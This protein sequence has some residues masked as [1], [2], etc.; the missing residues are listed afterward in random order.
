MGLQ[1]FPGGS[2]VK[3]SACNAGDL[4]SI[5]GLGRSPGEG[6]EDP[7]EKE[8]ATHSSVLG[9]R[10]PGTAEPGGLPSMGSHRVGHDWSDSSSG[11][12]LAPQ[13]KPPGPAKGTSK[14]P[15]PGREPEGTSDHCLCLAPGGNLSRTISQIAA[16][17]CDPGTQALLS[18]E[19]V[20]PVAAAKPETHEGAKHPR[21]LKAV[22]EVKWPP[23]GSRSTCPQ[24][25]KRPAGQTPVTANTSGEQMGLS[26]TSRGPLGQAWPWALELVSPHELFRRELSSLN[27]LRLVDRALLV[28]EASSFGSS[29][30]PSEGLQSR[31]GRGCPVGGPNF[32]PRRADLRGG[33]GKMG[34]VGL[35]CPL[36]PS[37]SHLPGCGPSRSASASF[38]RGKIT[39][40]S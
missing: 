4:G 36:G 26:H 14:P 1:G 39:I 32:S 7:L 16:G 9:W 25:P 15:G 8:M 34:M 18:T 20:E 30:L 23:P 12:V 3:A 33:A 22:E 27:L 24:A 17:L 29:S 19:G 35:M 21:P 31:R 6:W 2:E 5:P 28:S 11:L 10:T 40:L 37:L 38:F 13:T